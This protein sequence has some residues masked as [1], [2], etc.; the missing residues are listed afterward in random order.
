MLLPCGALPL[1]SAG[2]YSR[3]ALKGKDALEQSPGLQN[4]GAALTTHTNPPQLHSAP[5]RC[6]AGRTLTVTPEARPRADCY[7]PATGAHSGKLQ[8]ETN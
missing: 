6:T 4:G 7:A 8:G 3:G 5:L 2:S 1:G